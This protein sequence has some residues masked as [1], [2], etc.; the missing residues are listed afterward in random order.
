M[1]VWLHKQTFLGL[2]SNKCFEMPFLGPGRVNR[3]IR[4]FWKSATFIKASSTFWKSAIEPVHPSRPQKG[5]SK[6][7]LDCKT[8]LRQ[9]KVCLVNQTYVCDKQNLW[10][11]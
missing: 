7:L 5:I 1:Y 10:K 4:T 11:V 9:K 8:K 2:Q 3:F 6:H